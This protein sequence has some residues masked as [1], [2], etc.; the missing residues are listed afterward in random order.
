MTHRT[1]I[2][3]EALQLDDE[4]ARVYLKVL[5]FVGRTNSHCLAHHSRGLSVIR[6]EVRK[7]CNPEDLSDEVI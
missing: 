6:K 5:L 4:I 1:K 3:A 2:Q 7:H